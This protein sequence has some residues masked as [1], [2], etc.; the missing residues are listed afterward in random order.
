MC[1]VWST[2]VE[3]VNRACSRW[4]S[5]DIHSLSSCPSPFPHSYHLLGPCRHLSLQLLIDT[6]Y[7]TEGPAEEIER[8][9]GRRGR[10]RERMNLVLC[11]LFVSSLHF[12]TQMKLA[13]LLKHWSMETRL[14]QETSLKFGFFS[15]AMCLLL[16]VRSLPKPVCNIAL[17]CCHLLALVTSSRN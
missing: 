10:G 1:F 9:E 4:C 2:W 16:T 7:L 5:I 11:F 13:N 17:F 6:S 14:S 8:R 3:S 15:I 12:Q